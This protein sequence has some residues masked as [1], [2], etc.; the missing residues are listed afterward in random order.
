MPL[1]SD[2]LVLCRGR[3]AAFPPAE[4]RDAAVTLVLYRVASLDVLR[5]TD[6]DARS[7]FMRDLREGGRM[8]FP[9]M[10]LTMRILGHFSPQ[11]LRNR[12]NARAPC[13]RRL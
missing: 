13:M 7:M 4:I 11:Q 9:Q 5:M 12:P 8:S 6:R 3:F 2:F 1:T 10:Q